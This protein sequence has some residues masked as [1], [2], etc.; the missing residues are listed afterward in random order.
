MNSKVSKYGDPK[1]SG[2]RH[3]RRR[4]AAEY[5]RY[6]NQMVKNTAQLRDKDVINESKVSTPE[7]SSL[8]EFL[9]TPNLDPNT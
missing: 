5:R 6:V 1:F 9:E 4:K 3:E 2:N 8:Q 7:V